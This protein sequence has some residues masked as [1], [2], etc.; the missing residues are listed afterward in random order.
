MSCCRTVRV[1]GGVRGCTDGGGPAPG[2]FAKG[3]SGV[4]K[5]GGVRPI[6]DTNS[7]HTSNEAREE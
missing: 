7:T 2:R 1:E 3:V 4:M 5:G 6:P